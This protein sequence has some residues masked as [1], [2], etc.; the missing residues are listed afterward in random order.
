MVIFTRRAGS[1]LLRNVTLDVTK[2]PVFFLEFQVCIF[3]AVSFFL[4]FSFC[5][6]VDS[7]ISSGI[8]K[9]KHLSQ[10][11]SLT[12]SYDVAWRKHDF[13]KYVKQLHCVFHQLYKWPANRAD[14]SQGGQK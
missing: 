4:Y 3:E 5:K 7:N 6:V 11:T 8:M 1:I 10:I 2:C 14:R 12:S 13:A 9:S